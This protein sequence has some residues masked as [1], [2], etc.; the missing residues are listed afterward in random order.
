MPFIVGR[1]RARSYVKSCKF[2]GNSAPGVGQPTHPASYIGG[3]GG[4]MTLGASGGCGGM[5]LRGNVFRGNYARSKGSAIYFYGCSDARGH[6]RYYI[7]GGSFSGGHNGKKGIYNDL[8]ARQNESLTHIRMLRFD[9]A[10]CNPDGAPPCRWAALCRMDERT[11]V[12][13]AVFMGTG[14]I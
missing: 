2:Y 8:G 14:A 4:A 1:A 5:V 9:I 12:L 7:S 6:K 10:S 13:F 3:Y 11:A